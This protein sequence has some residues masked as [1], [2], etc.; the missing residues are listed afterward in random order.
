MND[1]KK[2]KPSNISKQNK[3]KR[4]DRISVNVSTKEII[5][6]T[7]E[8]TKSNV[9]RKGYWE[10]RIEPRLEQIAF[11][12]RKGHTDKQ[13]CEALSISEATFCK[14]KLE[15]IELVK[16]LK[17][18]K[19]IADLTVE[20]SLYKRANGYEYDEET[21]V[22]KKDKDGQDIVTKRT[23]VKKQVLPDTTAQI[24]WLKNRTREWTDRQVVS[25][26]GELKQ[27]HEHTIT[28]DEPQPDRLAGVLAILIQSGLIAGKLIEDSNREPKLIE[29]SH[30]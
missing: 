12:C 8:V 18:N 3:F 9:G 16:V 1:I 13:I 10:T 14:Y 11:W 15:K 26:E 5:P 21:K 27:S 7:K 4:K 6:V 24:F 19:E 28:I 2:N 30:S 23:I 17:V 29:G 25:H 20:N 22:I